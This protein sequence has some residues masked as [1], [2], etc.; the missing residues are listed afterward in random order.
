M[1]AYAKLLYSFVDT[2]E[3]KDCYVCMRLPAS[4]NEGM[5]YHHLPLTYG[6]SCS[7]LLSLFYDRGHYEYFFSNVDVVL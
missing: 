2:M 4:V 6:I 3:A 1:N 5:M 7:I